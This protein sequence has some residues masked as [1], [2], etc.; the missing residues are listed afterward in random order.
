MKE[1]SSETGNPQQ[2][3]INDTAYKELVSLIQSLLLLKPTDMGYSPMYHIPSHTWFAKDIND[4]LYGDTEVIFSATGTFL[5]EQFRIIKTLFHRQ[6]LRS[7]GTWISLVEN[8]DG[9]KYILKDSWNE[10]H[11]TPEW[12]W[13]AKV[14][15]K[16]HVPV[17]YRHQ[18]ATVDGHEDTTDFCRGYPDT[19]IGV[20]DENNEM[21][22]GVQHR[23]H[24]QLLFQPCGEPV[25][26]SDHPHDILNAI[27]GALKCE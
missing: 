8:N 6:S 9:V 19:G 2:F 25:L 10:Q 3:E 20:R 12:E 22:P 1:R 21:L 15:G 14:E 5:E 23:V 4:A 26:L 27:R 11:W 18:V 13:Y 16:P 24:E 17:L 7:R